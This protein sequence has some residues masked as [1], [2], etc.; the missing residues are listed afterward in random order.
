V[1]PFQELPSHIQSRYVGTIIGD[2]SMSGTA[3][4]DR[5]TRGFRYG[6]VAISVVILWVQSSLGRSQN[7][8]VICM[9]C[10]AIF[11]H[12]SNRLTNK[13]DRG[14]NVLIFM[15]AAFCLSF[16]I[17][18]A[19]EIGRFLP[20]GPLQSALI[21]LAAISGIGGSY[22]AQKRSGRAAI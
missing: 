13:N 2:W 16:S 22:L 19:N 11:M 12:I 7:D 10:V 17:L 3:G 14:P 15:L 6:A 1:P 5:V 18:F 9:I 4:T 8:F 20:N 21:V